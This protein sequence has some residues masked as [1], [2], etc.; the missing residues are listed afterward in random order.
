MLFEVAVE[1]DFL[2][3]GQWQGESHG[4]IGMDIG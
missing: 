1:F 2:Q 4:T 3:T